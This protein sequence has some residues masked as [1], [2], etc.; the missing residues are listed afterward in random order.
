MVAVN[1]A[2]Y[3]LVAR[4]VERDST[5]LDPPDVFFTVLLRSVM[6]IAAVQKTTALVFSGPTDHHLVLQ[7]VGTFMFALSGYIV[8]PLELRQA[9]TIMSLVSRQPD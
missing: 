7:A 1:T 3:Y 8:L 6:A 5:R 2:L 4:Q 9:A